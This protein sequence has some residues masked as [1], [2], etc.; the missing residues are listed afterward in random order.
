MQDMRSD[1]SE[2]LFIASVEE[3][4]LG[5][6]YEFVGVGCG[7]GTDLGTDFELFIVATGTGV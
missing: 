6:G 3:G 1:D 4:T 5:D 2:E 7:P